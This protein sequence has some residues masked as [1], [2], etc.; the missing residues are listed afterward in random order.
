MQSIIISV[1]TTLE[2]ES[3]ELEIHAEVEVT[4]DTSDFSNWGDSWPGERYDMNILH[5]YTVDG[6]RKICLT[7]D[8]KELILDEAEDIYA[9]YHSSV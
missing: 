1:Y 9:R 6:E 5:A 8:E 4:N 2:R 3:G 7:E